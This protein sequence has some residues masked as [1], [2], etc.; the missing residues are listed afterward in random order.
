MALDHEVL[1]LAARADA[2][3]RAS[4]ADRARHKMRRIRD[5]RII[6]AYRRLFVEADGT[7]KPDA[8][9]VIADLSAVARLGIVDGPTM[10]DAEMREAAGRRTMAL[11]LIA[12]MDLDGSR[13]AK[14]AAQLREETR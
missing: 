7:L 1:S 3:E 11:H 9:D 2:I 6:S 13:L 4:L 12:R 14:L 10:S 8:V 5:H